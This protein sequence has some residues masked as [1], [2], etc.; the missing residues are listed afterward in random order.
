MTQHMKKIKIQLSKRS[1]LKPGEQVLD[2][3]S[4]DATLLNF[5]DKKIIKVGIDPLVIKYIK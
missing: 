2:I 5:Y 1:K 4:N 3:A